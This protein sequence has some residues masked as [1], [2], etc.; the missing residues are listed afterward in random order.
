MKRRR[1][2]LGRDSGFDGKKVVRSSGVR[3]RAATVAMSDDYTL[4]GEPQLDLHLIL[5]QDVQSRRL[6][7][8]RL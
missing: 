3:R 2:G 5:T 8:E 4:A 1:A 7:F 6:K